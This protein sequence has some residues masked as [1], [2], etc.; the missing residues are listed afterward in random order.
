MLKE[1]TLTEND[2]IN[3]IEQL[4]LE[5]DE[6]LKTEEAEPSVDGSKDLAVFALSTELNVNSRN[7]YGVG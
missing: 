2:Q 7:L 6:I 5:D 1:L 4:R 3:I